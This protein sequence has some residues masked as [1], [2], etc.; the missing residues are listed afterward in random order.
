[1]SKQPGRP[2]VNI[3]P[4][5]YPGCERDPLARGLCSTHY[6]VLWRAGAAKRQQNPRTRHEICRVLGCTK[7]THR[8]GGRYCA[9]HYKRHR[10]NGSPLI[11]KPGVPITHHVCTVEGCKNIAQGRGLC[12][13]HWGRWDRTG[14]PLTPLRV[15]PW[16]PQEYERLISILDNTKGGIGRAR[17]GDLTDLASLTGRTPAACAQ[18]LS[19]LRK[20]RRAGL[21]VP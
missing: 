2:R 18:M 7:S 21:P 3:G 1:M 12:T 13:I 5:T 6:S 15:T 16:E 11:R 10:K 14:D 4:C 8:G 20:K 19:T 17:H 9:M